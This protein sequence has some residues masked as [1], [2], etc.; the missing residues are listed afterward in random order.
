MKDIFKNGILLKKPLSPLKRCPFCGAAGEVKTEKDESGK[1]MYYVECVQCHARTAAH[2]LS[3]N[4]I[5]Q[6]DTQ[7]HDTKQKKGE[8][9]YK[10]DEE[11]CYIECSVC[12]LQY[13]YEDGEEPFYGNFCYECGARLIQKEQTGERKISIWDQIEAAER[14]KEKKTEKD[15]E[16]QIEVFRRQELAEEFLKTMIG[17]AD[18]E[19]E[20]EMN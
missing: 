12:G 4:A 17:I 7:I 15:R 3:V 18:D 8:W 20:E 11:G 16:K 14:G 13:G 2:R 1:R 9:L 19:E 6:W 10:K 5:R